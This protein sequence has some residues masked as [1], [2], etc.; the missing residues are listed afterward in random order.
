M[1]TSSSSTPTAPPVCA[2]TPCVRVS[3]T[4]RWTEWSS[5]LP[6]AR[7]TCGAH[8]CRAKAT[9]SDDRRG[10]SSGRSGVDPTY[11]AGQTWLRTVGAST[12]EASMKF[13]ARHVAAPA[14]VLVL[15]TAAACGG[16]NTGNAT[17]KAS[18]A[19]S[20]PA[21]VTP[22]GKLDGAVTMPN[23]FPSDFPVYPGSRLTAARQ[24][25]ANGQTTWGVVWETL[26]GVDQVQ[27]FYV[28][29]LSDGDWMLTYN[30]SGSGTFSAIISRKSNQK[31]A[32]ILTVESES[33]VTH[34]ALA[35]GVPG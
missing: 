8:S 17:S 12:P 22:A 15:A 30:G 23:G 10:G 28:N 35:L 24:V 18:S 27:N 14:L 34:I 13:R 21:S 5:G 26:D 20:S 19:R 2:R 31:D 1:R 33:N 3:A 4:A 29:K 32:G 16:G 25:L 7:P 11:R 6:C 9:A